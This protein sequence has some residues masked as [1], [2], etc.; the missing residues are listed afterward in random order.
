MGLLIRFAGQWVAGERLED[1][2]RCAEGANARGIKAIVNLLGEHQ[3]DVSLLR[4]AREE[5][6]RVLDAIEMR[7]LRG[8]VSIKLS[9]FGL[10]FG[11]STCESHV[12]PLFDR[13]R[14]M[15]GFLWIDMEDSRFTEETLALYEDLHRRHHDVGVCLQAN[16][17]RTPKDLE[18]ILGFGGKV[19][20][21][22]GAYREAAA[23]AHRKRSEIDA[24]FGR[25]MHRMFEEGDR[26]AVA[27]HDSRLIDAAIRLAATHKRIWEF[28]FLKGVRDPLKR[29]LVA[30]GFQVSEYIPYGPSWLPYFLRRLR[31]RPRNALTMVRSFV[32]G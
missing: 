7:G 1:A 11:R 22:K 27:T 2:V 24:A 12:V 15:G 32:Q 5:Y 18:R 23:I 19:R 3:R 26:F 16:L 30:R 29:D 6:G 17:K 31:E 10:Q 8:C 9:Q 25:L 14:A 4:G 28:Q 20:L 21:T 13:I